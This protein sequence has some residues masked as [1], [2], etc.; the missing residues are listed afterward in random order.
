MR[1]LRTSSAAALLA[2]WACNG[3]GIPSEYRDTTVPEARLASSEARL[4]GRAFFLEHCAICHGERADGR[5]QRRNLSS[6]PQDLTD[7]SWQE[8]SS[9]QWVFYLIREG[10]PG[11]AMAAWKVLD[12]NETWDLVAYLLSLPDDGQ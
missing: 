12:A 9:P 10:K 6:Q 5:G 8:R 4:R 1:R 2:L 7:S 11:T 3:S